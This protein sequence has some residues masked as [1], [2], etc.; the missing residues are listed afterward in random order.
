MVVTAESP[1][2][3]KTKVG[4]TT[5]LTEDELNAVPQSRDPWSVIMTVPGI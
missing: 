3:D 4:T 2:M 5:V 1:L